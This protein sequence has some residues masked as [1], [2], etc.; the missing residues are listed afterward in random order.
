MCQC[1]REVSMHERVWMVER[2]I[3]GVACSTL[4]VGAVGC[5]G[6]IHRQGE[7]QFSLHASYGFPIKGDSIYP[8]GKGT[9]ENAGVTL[10]YSYFVRDRLALNVD[11]TPYRKYNQPN[12]NITAGE[13]QI[14][15]R[16]YF[17]DFDLPLGDIP[18]GFFGEIRGGLM[19][20]SKAVPELGSHTNFTQDTGIG[21]EARVTDN[22]SWISGYRYRHLSHGHVF[23]GD[24]NP[25]QNDNQVYTGIAITW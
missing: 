4:L 23:S 22:V 19:H 13:L 20:S 11:L 9:A 2:I 24:P 5:A 16:Y 14:G 25:S 18:V 6:G 8:E 3:A 7:Q 12:G 10:G 21:F 15:A 17:F 1:R